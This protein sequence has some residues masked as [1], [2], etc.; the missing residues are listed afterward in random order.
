MVAAAEQLTDVTIV[1][2]NAGIALGKSPLADGALEAARQELEVHY[3]GSLAV[4]RAFAPVLAANGGGALVNMLSALSWV[5][6][7]QLAT[8]AARRRLPGR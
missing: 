2:N 1:V 8:Y 5:T 3:L 4:T 7:P 6:F